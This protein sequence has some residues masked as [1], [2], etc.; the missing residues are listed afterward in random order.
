MS[1]MNGT[2]TSLRF[3]S[4]VARGVDLPTGLEPPEATA[5]AG[6][7]P[8]E[9]KAELI[10]KGGELAEPTGLK[11]AVKRTWAPGSLVDRTASRGMVLPA[12]GCL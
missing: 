12:T 3:L 8:E 10:R 9:G 7:L 11:S 4:K 1:S 2:S 6:L 5:E